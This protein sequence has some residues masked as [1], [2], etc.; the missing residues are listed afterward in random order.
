MFDEVRSASVAVLTPGSGCESRRMP[1]YSCHS[2]PT[3]TR[4]F[5][6]IRPVDSP[7]PSVTALNVE[8]GSYWSVMPRRRSWSAVASRKVPSFGSGAVAIA[9]I[10]PVV[11]WITIAVTALARYCTRVS[12]TTASA[13]DCTWRSMP[14][15]IVRPGC[16]CWLRITLIALPA[17]SAIRTSRPSLPRSTS[18]YWS[19]SPATPLPSTFVTPII[20]AAIALG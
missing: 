5:G 12:L 17:G 13:S 16:I 8:P 19:S 2:D 7:A 4:V 18:S 9:R 3:S 10:S 6:V 15:L 1:S 11:G 14:V 20:G